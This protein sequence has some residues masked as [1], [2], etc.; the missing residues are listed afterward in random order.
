MC[1]YGADPHQLL[2]T[3]SNM[4]GTWPKWFVLKGKFP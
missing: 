4:G 1:S 3:F 2:A